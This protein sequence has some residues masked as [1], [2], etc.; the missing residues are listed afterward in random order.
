M[1]RGNV[2]IIGAVLALLALPAAGE[3]PNLLNYEGRLTDPS[4]NPKNGTFTRGHFQG[5]HKGRQP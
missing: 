4:G 3:A 5:I 2:W 1:K